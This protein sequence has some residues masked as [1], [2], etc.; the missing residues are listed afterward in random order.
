MHFW[1]SQM[2]SH[3][4]SPGHSLLSPSAWRH[5]GAALRLSS[6]ELQIIQG[7]FDDQKEDGIAAEMGISAHT[8]NTYFRRLYTKL[9]VS[10]RPQLIVRVM[11]EDLA[12][13]AP[14]P[15][16]SRSNIRVSR[17]ETRHMNM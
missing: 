12:A 3:A 9:G 7:V 14:V 8:V 15:G 11:A 16:S 6:R 2:V 13:R 5:L 17:C 1:A 10:S 4:A